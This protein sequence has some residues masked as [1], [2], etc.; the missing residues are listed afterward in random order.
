MGYSAKNAQ[1][2]YDIIMK[3]IQALA[4]TDPRDKVFGRSFRR[5]RISGLLSALE[6]IDSSAA[7][8][9]ID[10]LRRLTIASE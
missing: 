9:L 5:G 1:T 6:I 10:D 2:L 7:I 3:E 4:E 8:E